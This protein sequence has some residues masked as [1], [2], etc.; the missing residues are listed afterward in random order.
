ME[1]N[2]TSWNDMSSQAL[3][4]WTS[5][6]TQIWKNWFDLM[7]STTQSSATPT[8]QP[9]FQQ[10]TQQFAS[11]QQLIMRLLQLSFDT[12]RDLFPKVEAGQ[13]WQQAMTHYNQQIQ[14]QIETFSHSN[15][16]IYQDATELWQ[17]Y[18][19][20]WQK[21]S[22]L[23]MS[24]LGNAI[25]PM[26]QVGLGNTSEPWLELNNLY[27]NLLYEESFGSLMQSPLLGPSREFNGKLLRNFDAWSK[28]YRA[29]L[30]YQVV[31]TTVQTRSF[32][33]LMQELVTMAEQG[34]TVKD[35]KEFQQIWSRVA[36]D[37]FEQAF[38]DENNLKVRGRFLN[39]LNT[40][41]I[42]QQDLMELW[43]KNFNIPSRNEVDEVHRSLYELRKEMKQLKKQ[44]ARY[45]GQT[46]AK[47]DALANGN[48]I[49]HAPENGSEDLSASPSTSSTGGKTTSRRSPR[50]P[51]E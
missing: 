23:W 40:Y 11:N 21:V 2:T 47:P 20:E 25:G 1:N 45:E 16:K 30:D 34:K 51:K 49:A 32:E 46:S 48:T 17:L 44:L 50:T 8:S 14:S 27:W 19:Q 31:L 42:H 15:L 24:S 36:D 22:Q 43:M 39:A 12:W 3:N 26:S 13:D 10:V 5:A 4:A 35:W 6:G 28:L 9:G 29:T 37:V 41:R 33:R 18:L 7:G 38:C